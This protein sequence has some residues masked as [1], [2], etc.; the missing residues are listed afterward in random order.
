VLSNLRISTRLALLIAL[1]VGAML[2]IGG[3]AA[4]A[5]Q[6]ARG[7][8]A[9]G[10]A[11]AAD[12]LAASDQVRSA[13]VHFRVQMQ[14]FKNILLRGQD[15]GEYKRHLDNFSKRDELAVR[16]LEAARGTLARIGMPTADA[17]DAAR[18]QREITRQY[19]EALQLFDPTHPGSSALVDAAVRG[20][21]R[22]LEEKIERAVD[23]VERF[24]QEDSARELQAADARALL[25]MKVLGGLVLVVV[26]AAT[27]LGRVFALGISRPLQHAAEA[28]QR[29]ARG[30]LTQDVRVRGRDETGQLLVA[31][32]VMTR[33][34][35]QLLAELAERAHVVA[36]ASEQIAQ[37]NT[38]LSQRTEE[39][40]STLEETASQ[41]EELT[42]TVAGNAE[43]AREASRV[44][45]GA[46]EV[47]TRG[48]EAVAQVVLKMSGISAASGRI[49]DIIG[50][51]DG[52]AFQTN[53]LALNAAV[54]A[55][56]AGEQGRGFAVVAAEVR[57]L[58]QRSAAAAK[59][60]KALIGDS[61]QQV[62]AGA[63]LVDAAGRTMDDI[64]G[65]V[66]TVSNLIAEIASASL[67]QSTG[68][69]QVNVAVTQMDQVVQQNAALVEEA[70]AATE[71]MKDQAR[72]LL[73]AV[74]RF[75]LGQEAVA[76]GASAA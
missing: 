43:H 28:A 75:D 49:S 32:D 8:A 19:L 41:M 9:A 4:Y 61:T 57:N 17:D 21:D 13:E 63:R 20:K 56:R 50:V 46:S 12:L 70:A 6:A 71:S 74:G 14:E 58:A 35:R 1:M 18:M 30:D 45:A 48:G 3:H 33:N 47:A 2:V 55:A 54:E 73:Q 26:L 25:A 42:A 37:G 39:Q 76:P 27:L 34:L 53:L 5:L 22:P 69:E 60:I 62:E 38:D 65:S 23:G 31:V 67:E 36:D 59:E 51:I 64:V 24:A 11:R 7:D 16:K 68:I 66:R 44:A 10:L 40:A 72:A 52:I 29:V 15:P